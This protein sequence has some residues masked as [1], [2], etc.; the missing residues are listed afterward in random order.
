MKTL[1]YAV[2]LDILSEGYDG[3]T[4]WFQPRASVIPPN[5]AVITAT[6][7]DLSGSDGLFLVYTRRGANNDHVFRNRAPL[8]MA[9]VD[10]ERLRVV[11]QT[12]RVLLPEKGAQF[13]NFGVVNASAGESWVLD[14][15]GM[16]G[17]AEQPFDIAR[18]VHRGA[19]NRLYLCRIL[20][21]KPNQ[22]VTT[23]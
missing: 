16:Q 11:R 7:S 4:Q 17:D 9:Q 19:N 8:F 22:M 15:E 14:A 2:K 23:R 21:N 10:V 3:K 12:E 13:G 6:R 18:T 5:T 1:D 20:W